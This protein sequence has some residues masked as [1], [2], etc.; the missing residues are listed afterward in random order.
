MISMLNRLR[1]S[2]NGVKTAIQE[3]ADNGMTIISISIRD[4]EGVQVLIY[5]SD[6]FAQ[7]FPNHYKI[8][9]PEDDTFQYR[10]WAEYEGIQFVTL[11]PAEKEVD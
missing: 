5:E 3:I 9:L 7:V 6:Q 2:I 8:P 10:L 11:C 1:L 4:P